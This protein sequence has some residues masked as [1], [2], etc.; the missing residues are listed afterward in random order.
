MDIE[1]VDWQ[2]LG[3]RAGPMLLAYVLARSER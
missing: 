3:W 1:A 2:K